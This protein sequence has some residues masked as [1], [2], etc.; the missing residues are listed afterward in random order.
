MKR[1]PR[2]GAV[3]LLVLGAVSVLAVLAVE[4]AHRSQI[5]A[6]EVSR[7]EREA[8]FRRLFDS[9]IETAKGLLAEKRTD[10]RFDCWG[11]GWREQVTWEPG[12]G[13][14]V[15]LCVEDESGKINFLRARDPA[16]GT[17]TRGAIARLFKYLRKADPEREQ[18]WRQTEEKLWRR[19]GVTAQEAQEEEA[20]PRPQ[21]G[22]LKKFEDPPLTLD[23]LREAGI[24]LEVVFRAM[25]NEKPRPSLDRYLTTFGDGRVNLNTA[26]LAVLYAL[27]PGLD[28][29]LAWQ[30][31]AWRGGEGGEGGEDP[32]HAS[33]NR[34]FLQAMDLERVPG[35]VQKATID[36]EEQVIRNIHANVQD[37]VGVKGQVFSVRMT[38]EVDGRKRQAVAYVEAGSAA[39]GNSALQVLAYEEIE[40]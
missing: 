6:I 18:E 22:T 36:G 28:E 38:A 15:T 1:S 7:Y 25:D 19:L 32:E 26:P 20:S 10:P 31:A 16:G 17:W 39:R 37:H 12:Q 14:R 35:I 21:A 30:I 5:Q 40:P 8:E 34:A 13:R 4:V 9:G 29:D 2:R 3:L 24:P 27:D 11:D 23:G 33:S